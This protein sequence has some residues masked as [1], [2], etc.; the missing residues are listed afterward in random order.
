MPELLPVV[1]PVKKEAKLT[2]KNILVAAE[3]IIRVSAKPVRLSLVVVLRL[4][5]DDLRR[6]IKLPT[7]VTP[8]IILTIRIHFG[9]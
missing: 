4:R 7:L 2:P 3:P 9:L 5:F 8:I 1:T 6:A